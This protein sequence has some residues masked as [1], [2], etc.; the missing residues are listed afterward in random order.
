MFTAKRKLSLLVES[1]VLELC[2]GRDLHE[3]S[4]TAIIINLVDMLSKDSEVMLAVLRNWCNTLLML[5]HLTSYR[6]IV[7]LKSDC[8][9][10]IVTRFSKKKSPWI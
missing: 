5:C 8:S 10:I 6:Y 1:E 7:E 3:L 9:I 4:L 2:I